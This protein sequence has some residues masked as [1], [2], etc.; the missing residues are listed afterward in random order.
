MPGARAFTANARV[1]SDSAKSTAVYAPALTISS[2]RAWRTV[3][4]MASASARSSAA[5]SSA[6][7]SPWSARARASS[8]PTGPPAPVRRMVGRDIAVSRRRPRPQAAGLRHPLPPAGLALQRPVDGERG[9]V[10]AQRAFVLADPVVG[11]LVEKFGDSLSTRKPWAKPGGIHSMR[12]V[13]APTART[14]TH[15]RRWARTGAGRP[16]RRKLRRRPP[17]PACPAAAGSGSAGRAARPLARAGVVVLHEVGVDPGQLG[18][19][20]RHCS[21]RRRSRARRRTPRL[22]DQDVR[23]SGRRDRHRP[24]LD[25]RTSAR[26]HLSRYWP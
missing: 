5:R 3:A 13:L 4:T 23:E 14:P 25:P 26:Q 20:P 15:G 1:L 7:T 22:D 21:S 6:I 12:L 19:A 18:E 11:G 24:H 10:P 9:I 16:P 8:K 2:G 17:A